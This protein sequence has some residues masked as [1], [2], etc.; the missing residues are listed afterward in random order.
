MRNRSRHAIPS[1]GPLS[2][3]APR[4]QGEAS[5]R[6][7]LGQIGAAHG[8]GGEV[9]LYSFTAEPEAIASYGPLETDDGRA[10]TIESLRPAKDHFVARLSGIG[11]R[12]AAR[13]LVNAKLYVPRE[14]LPDPEAGEFYHA[15]LIGLA[16]VDRAGHRLGRVVAVRNF[17]A[18]DLIEVRGDA[19]SE[20]Q[21][22]PFDE[23]HVPAVDMVAGTIVVEPAKLATTAPSARRRPTRNG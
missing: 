5:R 21:L 10:F 12:E 23:A 13:A 16:V 14:R 22:L 20:T 15:D 8:V 4:R 1:S 3:A 11:D 2:P 7:C 18:G 17:G 6:V 19:G 9:R